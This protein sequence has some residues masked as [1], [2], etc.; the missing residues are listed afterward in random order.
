MKNGIRIASTIALFLNALL[1][2]A[3]SQNLPLSFKG[4]WRLDLNRTFTPWGPIP[5]SVT[6]T[7]TTDD[8]KDFDAEET[9]GRNGAVIAAIIHT[10]IDGKFYPVLGVPGNMNAAIT[11]WGARFHSHGVLG[12][13]SS[14]RGDM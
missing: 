13:R 2:P 6:I 3:L 10:P 4:Q 11:R 12:E 14:W 9:W 1:T 8:G 7:V 5:K